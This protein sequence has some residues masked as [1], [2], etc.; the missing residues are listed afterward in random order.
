MIRSTV[1]KQAYYNGMFYMINKYLLAKSRFYNSATTSSSKPGFEQLIDIFTGNSDCDYNVNSFV[2]L[3]LFVVII[4]SIYLIL[5]GLSTI[6]S[7]KSK[8]EV[9]SK[10]LILFGVI[11]FIIIYISVLS[12]HQV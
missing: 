5:R 8:G 4:L 11:W 7:I 3:F 1:S 12:K 9:N 2:K 6:T 10:S